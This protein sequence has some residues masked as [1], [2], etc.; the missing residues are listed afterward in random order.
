M[1]EQLF[2]NGE[3][4]DLQPNKAITIN[5]KSNFMGDVSKIVASNSNTI[6]LPKTPRN[7]AIF[8]NA[9]VPAGGSVFPYRKWPAKYYRDGVEIIPAA[10]CVL[11]DVGDTYNVAL[12]WG[13]MS[14][15][16]AWL[17]SEATL[18]Q[19]DYTTGDSVEFVWG[20][21]ELDQATDGKGVIMADYD[22]GVG[23]FADLP[24]S[25]GMNPTVRV[26]SILSKIEDAV[27][28]HFN[29]AFREDDIPPLAQSPI[30][31]RLGVP[32]TT[33][34]GYDSFEFDVLQFVIQQK[35]EE[36]RGTW[37][38]R[39]GLGYTAPESGFFITEEGTISL[40]GKGI[41]AKNI[42]PAAAGYVSA[43]PSL[44]IITGNSNQYSGIAPS[45][46]LFM[47][48]E[49]A[50]GVSSSYV[51][52]SS[53]SYPVGYSIRWDFYGPTF[54]L[55]VPEGGKFGFVAMTENARI[56][57]FEGSVK[58]T[59][60]ETEIEDIV[61]GDTYRVQ[62]NLPDMKQVDFV[63]AIS[64][65]LGLFAVQTIKRTNTITFASV[66]T[67]IGNKANAY[68]WT[69]R[70]LKGQRD[71]CP[72]STSF[73]LDSWAKENLFK[74]EEDETVMNDGH[75]TLSVPN[76]NLE[77]SRDALTLPF[78][79]SD[80]SVVP[81]YKW[82][83]EMTEV[84]RVDI[85]PRIMGIVAKDNGDAALT[86]SGLDW[87]SLLG[88]YYSG[89]SRMLDQTVAIKCKVMLTA[90]ELKELSFMRP[91]YL[92]QFG[93]Y[94]AIKSVSTSSSEECSVELIQLPI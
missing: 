63:R 36:D 44:S 20:R 43:Y 29:L 81:I 54:R 31:D 58:I 30:T 82:N 86:F 40:F 57:A 33:S 42:V 84:E 38:G 48:S 52:L 9:G 34:K 22:T 24:A 7:N 39:Y 45:L 35:V 60:P 89:Q 92:A 90:P 46:K 66:D 14:N 12:Y 70:L 23:S 5:Y 55:E 16:Q 75:G 91:V 27:G 87:P 11:V 94:Y 26:S 69:G 18:Q 15:F 47:V 74:Y 4:V 19:L 21:R 77:P 10:Y 49:S 17:D 13:V 68:D 73:K 3:E 51:E 1:R 65:M 83:D 41:K 50:D 64:Q 72:E 28:V 93:R 8:M 59:I 6:N 61:V 56:L 71:G 2:L 76:E 79:A 80:W 67:L 62:N 32:L 53:Y 25:V 88:R 78:A 37:Y 85:K